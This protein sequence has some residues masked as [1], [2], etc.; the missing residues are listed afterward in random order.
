[1][2]IKTRWNRHARHT[3][4]NKGL[5]AKILETGKWCTVIAL[6]H[7]QRINTLVHSFCAFQ[8]FTHF[9]SSCAHENRE[10]IPDAIEFHTALK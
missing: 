10:R 4:I 9:E 6:T 8:A 2:N 7:K 3:I 5:I 1:M